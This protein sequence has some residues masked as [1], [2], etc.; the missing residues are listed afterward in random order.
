MEATKERLEDVMF[1]REQRAAKAE[2]DFK[3]TV[4]YYKFL[5]VEARWGGLTSRE[6][7]GEGKIRLIVLTNEAKEILGIKIDREE[8]AIEGEVEVWAKGFEASHRTLTPEEIE[9][10]VAN[11]KRELTEMY[12]DEKTPAEIE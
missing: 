2:R 3:T 7:D 12:E 5:G 10:A 8:A 4:N 9:T 11:K 6:V 1:A